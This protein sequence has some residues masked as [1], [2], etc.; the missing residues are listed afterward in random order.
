[1]RQGDQRKRWKGHAPGDTWLPGE[2][3]VAMHPGG[4]SRP[5]GTLLPCDSRTP[6]WGCC[7]DRSIRN[8]RWTPARSARRHTRLS[9]DPPEERPV[10]RPRPA[11]H[12]SRPDA[13]RDGPGGGT[14][15]PDRGPQARQQRAQPRHRR[16]GP[17]PAGNVHRHRP[18]RHRLRRQVPHHLPHRGAGEGGAAVHPG[19]DRRRPGGRWHLRRHRLPDQQPV[20]PRARQRADA[21]LLPVRHRDSSGGGRRCRQAGRRP[22][23]HGRG[24]EPEEDRHDRQVHR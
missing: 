12:R 4:V 15:P 8:G 19:A 17:G 2:P 6:W 14:G 11:A 13:R 18:R 7:A 3:S 22:G 23:D 24:R 9:Q 20:P 10:R 21:T 5:A 16:G 1:M